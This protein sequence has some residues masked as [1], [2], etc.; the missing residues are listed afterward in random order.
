MM[1]IDIKALRI[2]GIYQQNDAGQLMMRVKLAGGLLSVPQAAALARL[3]QQYGSGAFHLTTRGSLEFHTLEADQIGPIQRSMAAVGLF[4]RGAC[5]GAVRGISCSSSFG[6]GFN[7]SQVLARQLLFHFS[8]N[9]HFEGL[10]KKFKIAV[11]ADYTGSR[12]LIQDLAFVYVGLEEGRALYDVWTGGGLGREPQ[13]AILYQQRVAE[14]ELL[15]LTES[16]LRIYRDNV[17][18]PKRLKSLLRSRGE[19]EFRRMLAAEL[20]KAA[21]VQFRNGFD[22]ALLPLPAENAELKLLVPVFAGELPA[23]R[24]GIIAAAAAAVGLDYLVVTTNQDLALL[25]ADPATRQ[26]LLDALQQAGIT[27]LDQ[28]PQQLRVCPGNHGCCMG[29]AATRDLATQLQQAFG[30]RLNARSLAISGCANSCAQ[31]QLAELGIV[32]GKSVRDEDGH[33]TPRFN[34]YRRSGEGL[35]ERIA[36]QLTQEELQAAL[37]P[38]L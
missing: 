17:Q 3:G 35:G 22:K 2:E 6:R 30:T 9:P 10:P 25:P 23:E 16:I 29:L 5:G 13:A 37:E 31:P 38:L 1:E 18:P 4:S 12:H 32:T 8:G 27:G 26:R 7:H 20:S 24:L 21:P 36:E 11:E 33:R 19:A 34:L 14:S 15:P 28:P